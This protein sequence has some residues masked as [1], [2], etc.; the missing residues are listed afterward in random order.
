MRST[1][2]GR[3]PSED[4]IRSS[5]KNGSDVVFG[6]GGG[7][8]TLTKMRANDRVVR[9]LVKD[10][11]FRSWVDENK[12]R[13]IGEI[14]GMYTLLERST[15]AGGMNIDALPQI[16]RERNPLIENIEQAKRVATLGELTTALS[17]SVVAKD[18][19]EIVARLCARAMID[20][21][22]GAASHGFSAYV[23]LAAAKVHKVS[24][25]SYRKFFRTQF[26]EIKSDL[27]AAHSIGPIVEAAVRAEYAATQAWF[28]ERGIERLVVFRGMT[29]PKKEMELEWGDTVK[30]SLNPLSSW[31]TKE[32]EAARFANFQGTR[33]DNR[34]VIA[35]DVPVSMIQSIP[36]TGKGC[37]NEFEVVL[38]GKPSLAEVTMMSA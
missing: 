26:D 27:S 31:A 11:E 18:R 4:Q 36:F 16:V 25:A 3:V 33:S 35:S 15:R 30:T 29:V 8:A 28:K 10:K 19:E 7:D 22:A 37:L 34:F 32:S 13:P 6:D 38:I 17:V 21:W 9:E 20:S 24:T 5:Q 14:S 2:G 23:Q 12:N 1:G